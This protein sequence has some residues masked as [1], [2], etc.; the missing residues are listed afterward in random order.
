MVEFR[1]A[2]LD[3]GDDSKDQRTAV[4]NF[5]GLLLNT[6]RLHILLQAMK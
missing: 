3:V 4:Y 6:N 1:L 5:V 2:S